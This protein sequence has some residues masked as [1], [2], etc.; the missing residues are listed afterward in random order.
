MS[1]TANA[2][3]IDRR[4]LMDRSVAG[5]KAFTLPESDVPSQD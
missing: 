2:G 3:D 1:I 4:L 5:R